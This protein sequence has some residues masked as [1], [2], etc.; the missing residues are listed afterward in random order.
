MI[1]NQKIV[2]I[3][4]KLI[5][6]PY[7]YQTELYNACSTEREIIIN[8]SRQVGV[9]YC[10]ACYALVQSV[11]NNRTEL[12]ISPSLR[13]SKHMMDYVYE[14]LNKLRNDFKVPLQE[15]TKTSIIFPSGGRIHSL[16][17]S[18]NTVRGFPA[19]DIWID[20]YAHF[21]NGTDKEIIEA[22][23]PSISRGGNIR[24]ISTP[25]GDQNLFCQ[26]WNNRDIKKILINW[27][28]CP[29][30][31]PDIIKGIKETIGEDAFQQ[32]YN[33]QFLSDMEGQEFPMELISSCIDHELTYSDLTD[34]GESKSYI[35]GADIGREHDLTAFVALEKTS[36]DH[37]ILR[38]K[39]TMKNKPYQ[40]QMDFFN[41]QLI[42]HN[43]DSFTIDESGIGH[44]LSEQL[45]RNHSINR[46]TFNNEN[47]Q[48]MVGNLKK[49][50]QNHQIS[51]P[52]DP[53]LI[54]SIRSIRRIYTPSNYLRFDSGRDDNIGHADLFWALALALNY[55]PSGSYFRI[56]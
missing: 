36:D 37:Y 56:G 12:I 14:F 10:V 31:N 1:P 53:Q 8:K 47:K 2:A 41:Y 17:N 24:Y 45:A 6:E 46:I 50:M 29:D 27:K 33:N 23:T 15:E 19:D 32:E 18:A 7:P 26:T 16:P 52:N 51:F 39:Q 48:E 13:Q 22:I 30:F 49:M 38:Y 11:F 5:G 21:T 4:T 35:G 54:D 28:D 42:N 25:F 44:M 3:T 20:E 34:I 40:E 43:F 55:K 9:S